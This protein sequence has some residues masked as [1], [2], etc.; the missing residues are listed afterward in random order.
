MRHFFRFLHA[1]GEMERD[2]TE[3]IRSPAPAEAHTEVVAPEDLRRLLDT[4]K[5]KDFVSRR[6]TAILMGFL[7]GGLRLA[8]LAGMQVHDVDVKDRMLYVVGKGSAR[9]GPRPRAVPLGV[10]ATQAFDRYLRERRRHPWA[11]A[12]ALW[13]GGRNRGPITPA[14]IK[15]TIERRGAA[16][17]LTL[18]PHMLRHTWAHQFRSGGGSEGDLM[19][20]GGWKSRAMLDRYGRAA[21][22][23]RAREAARRHS[24]GDRL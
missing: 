14:S 24:L 1:E 13:L 16:V 22:S 8:E 23:E 6:D 10:K 7:D 15:R 3:G 11:D 5:G 21:A 9:S 17:G 4:C 19:V 18:H 12:D 2:P 20:I